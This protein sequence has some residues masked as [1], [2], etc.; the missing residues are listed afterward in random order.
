[1]STRTKNISRSIFRFCEIALFFV[2]SVMGYGLLSK[3]ASLNSKDK[4]RNQVY[5]VLNISDFRNNGKEPCGIYA[6]PGIDQPKLFAGHVHD[7][8]HGASKYDTHSAR[9]PYPPR[10]LAGTACNTTFNTAASS[11]VQPY[12][13]FQE[14]PVLLI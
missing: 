11:H 3:T 6:S 14:N 7:S 13:L 1:M 5:G 12:N 4:S 10:P 9:L 2:I 8:L